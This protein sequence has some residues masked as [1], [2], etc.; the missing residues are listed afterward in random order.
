MSQ[1]ND[2]EIESFEP[3]DAVDNR[4]GLDEDLDVDSEDDGPASDDSDAD[5]ADDDDS[6][7]DDDDDDDDE[8]EDALADEIDFVIAAYREDGQLS[9]SAL[10]DDLAND[11]EELIVQ[12][13]RLPGD[14]GAIGFVSLVEEVLVAVRVRGRHVQVVLNDATAALDWPI[15]RDVLDLLG[16][17]LPDS[18]DEAEPVGDLSM[19]ADLGLS[20][21]DLGTIIDDLD[22]AS[23]QALMQIADKINIGPQ[24]R[25]VAETALQD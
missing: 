14:A 6:D 20:D 10:N 4:P 5:D 15:A 18:D 24:F 9:V 11:L 7:D 8:P 3:D 2:E 16:E 21:F 25:K 22:L 17:E 1:H 19:F 23:D 12:L 13:R